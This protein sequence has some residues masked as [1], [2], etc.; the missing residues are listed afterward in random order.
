MTSTMN[1]DDDDDDHH[2]SDSSS[3]STVSALDRNPREGIW[4]GKHRHVHVWP[5]VLS[6]NLAS[7]T[8]RTNK[9]ALGYPSTKA[10]ICTLLRLRLT[11]YCLRFQAE[12]SLCLQHFFFALCSVRQKISS[13]RIK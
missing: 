13:N 3:D 1:D 12:P 10:K 8:W 6:L 7:D 2:R 11:S 5:K 9:Q 4:G